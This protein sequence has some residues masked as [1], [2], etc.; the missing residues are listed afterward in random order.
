MLKL[1]IINLFCL[2]ILI[3]CQS[4]VLTS[5]TLINSNNILPSPRT[6]MIIG[7]DSITNKIY[8]LGGNKDT[9]SQSNVYIFDVT[10]ETF[11]TSSSLSSSYST[12][13]QCYVTINRTI[14]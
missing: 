8:L 4:N 2:I 10:S 1:L 12:L 9:L 14:Y 13:S 11:S 3:N 7:Y 5:W 6:G